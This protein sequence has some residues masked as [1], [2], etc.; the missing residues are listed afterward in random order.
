MVLHRPYF[1][2]LVPSPCSSSHPNHVRR[3]PPIR[4][5]S[6]SPFQADRYQPYL[7]PPLPSIRPRPVPLPQATPSAPGSETLS[8]VTVA[9]RPSVSGSV[10]ANSHVLRL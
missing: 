10:S 9:D 2:M 7:H 6:H 8:S 3:V 4:T 5:T 1:A